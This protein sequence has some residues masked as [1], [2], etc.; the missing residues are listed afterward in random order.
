M[1]HNIEKWQEQFD[2][3]FTTIGTG[4]NDNGRK[5][6]ILP[7][8]LNSPHDAID[9]KQFISTL[10]KQE[11]I[12]MGEMLKLEPEIFYSKDQSKIY[13]AIARYLKKYD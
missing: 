3:K 7:R 4:Y 1:K 9:I 8:I 12:K 10:L 6:K 5:T 2:K 11:K 13:K